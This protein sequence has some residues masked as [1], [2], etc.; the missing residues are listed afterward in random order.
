M[1]AVH[2]HCGGGSARAAWCDAVC[3][4]HPPTRARL[5]HTHASPL[6]AQFV[7]HEDTGCL[8]I[9]KWQCGSGKDPQPEECAG[10]AFPVKGTYQ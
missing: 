4:T 3:I 2:K 10:F 6:H 5:P 9:V 8:K 1:G 7:Q